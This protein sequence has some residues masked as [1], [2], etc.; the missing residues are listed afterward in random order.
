VGRLHW[1]LEY[2]GH[3]DVYV[4]SSGYEALIEK[5]SVE[6][7]AEPNQ[8]SGNFVVRRRESIRAS[9]EEIRKVVDGEASGVLIDTRRRTEFT[10]EEVRAPRRGYIPKA[11]LYH[12]EEVFD[13]NGTLRSKS[14]LKSELRKEGLMKK[15]TALIPYCQTGTRSGVVYSVLRWAG[16]SNVQNYDGSWARW[17]RLNDAPIAKDG[18]ERL[19]SSSP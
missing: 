7:E 15:G 13:E 3:G 11:K 4:Y 1:A 18:E 2:L 19:A 10:G 5:T 12:W 6:A 9:N 16:A 8:A 14:E 17:A